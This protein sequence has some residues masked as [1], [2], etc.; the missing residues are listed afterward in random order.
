MRLAVVQLRVDPECRAATFQS[1]L[2]AVDTAAEADPPPD[3]VV[4]PAFMDVP[5]IM[6]GKPHQTEPLAGPT[7]AAFGHRARQWGIFVVLGFA[8]RGSAK[9]HVTTVLL[10]RDGDVRGAHRQRSPGDSGDPVE[11]TD[12]LLGSFALLAGEDIASDEIWHG[13]RSAGPS[14]V[15][16]ASCRGAAGRTRSEEPADTRRS[17]AARAA[18][19]GVC[20]ALADVVTGDAGAATSGGISLIVDA[21]GSILAAGS[22]GRDEI[23]WADVKLDQQTRRPDAESIA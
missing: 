20:L 12:V 22:P 10:D 13:V 5:S 7:V 14:C 9:T 15:L 2:R 1:A 19:A 18:S 11:T 17:I 6:A 23:L 8:E 3:L 21:A 16:C 4:L